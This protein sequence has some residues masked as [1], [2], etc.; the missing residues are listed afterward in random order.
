[1]DERIG[2][3]RHRSGPGHSPVTKALEGAWIIHAAHSVLVIRVR[4]DRAHYLHVARTL[5]TARLA[6]GAA[7]RARCCADREA[8]TA[9]CCRPSLMR[10]A[11]RRRPGDIRRYRSLSDRGRCAPTGSSGATYAA[12]VLESPYRSLTQE[13]LA[14]R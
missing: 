12:E 10:A 14:A 5:T 4:A 2:A 9:P 8:F 1:L 6:S 11:C 7:A 13:P 3:L